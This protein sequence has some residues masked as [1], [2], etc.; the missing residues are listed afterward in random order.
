MR[1]GGYYI[2]LD[3]DEARRRDVEAQ[4][5][6]LGLAE[7]Y[8]RFAAVDGRALPPRKNAGNPAELGCYLSHLEVIRRNIDFDGWLHIVEDDVVIS[9]HAA[10]AIAAVTSQAD[11]ARHDMIFTNVMFLAPSPMIAQLCGLFDSSVET[12]ASGEVVSVKTLTAV[13][14]AGL[15]F[16]Q[17]TSYLINPRS[18]G[19]VA[20]LLRDALDDQPLAPIDVA[21]SRLSRSGA[22]SMACTMPFFTVPRLG[23][24]STIAGPGGDSLDVPLRIMDTALFADRDVTALRSRLDDLGRSLTRSVTSELVAKAYRIVLSTRPNPEP[25][26]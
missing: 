21:F 17:T 22:L 26:R 19:R 16:V 23:A 1:W 15:D 4:L 9:R 11:F 24:S 8:Q 10:S 2:N 25:C 12:T 5:Q 18:I 3:R 6:H 7:R 13:P 20:D 14:L